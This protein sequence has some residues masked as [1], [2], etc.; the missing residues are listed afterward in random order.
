VPLSERTALTAHELG[1]N[2]N[3]D[4]CDGAN[5]CNIMC[6]HIDGCSGIGLP[7]FEPVGANE[8]MDFADARSCLDTPVMAVNAPGGSGAVRLARPSPSPFT[9]RTRLSYYLEHASTVRLAIYDVAGQRVANLV[10]QVEAPGW[11]TRAWDGL[12]RRGA[13]LKPGVFYARLEARGEKHTQKLI[14]VQ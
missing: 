8:I 9:N 12:D 2:W 1:H 4:H 11:H 13:R 14:L 5:P 6:S 10:D 7:N 3:A